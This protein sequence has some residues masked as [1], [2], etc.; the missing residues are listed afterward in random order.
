MNFE[1]QACCSVRIP[2]TPFKLFLEL[3][4]EVKTENVF[5]ET[6]YVLDSKEAGLI[7]R[8]CEDQELL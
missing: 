8:R 5:S 1:C 2:R 3:E 7:Q 4:F 6:A